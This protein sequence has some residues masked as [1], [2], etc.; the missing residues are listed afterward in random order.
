MSG[1]VLLPKYLLESLQGKLAEKQ[2]ESEWV[3][4]ELGAESCNALVVMAG[5][6]QHVGNKNIRLPI[7]I[8]NLFQYA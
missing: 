4:W 1:G 5:T 8:A 2:V 3:F 7:N 6:Q